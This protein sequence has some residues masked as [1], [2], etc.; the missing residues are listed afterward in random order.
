MIYDALANMCGEQ[1]KLLINATSKNEILT[2]ELETFNLNI[3]LKPM[4]IDS[5]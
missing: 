1:K 4:S 5:Y 2:K 3:K